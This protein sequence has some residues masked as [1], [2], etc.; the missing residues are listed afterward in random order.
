VGTA[1]FLA[2]Q[3]ADVAETRLIRRDSSAG[4]RFL[5]CRAAMVYCAAVANSRIG[6]TTV[7]SNAL[8]GDETMRTVLRYFVLTVVLSTSLV[9]SSPIL[10]ADH[11][12]SRQSFGDW[13]S[14]FH[15]FSYRPYYYKP[16][17]QFVGHTIM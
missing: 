17:P 2:G 4:L 8:I 11:F 13:H 1:G 9:G 12:G 5:Y 6:A 7:L 16:T 14:H 15:G 10:A 3:P